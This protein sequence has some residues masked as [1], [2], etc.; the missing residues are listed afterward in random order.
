MDKF[1]K[2][3]GNPHCDAIWHNIPKKITRCK[4]CNGNII[5]INEKTYNK[6]FKNNFFQ[7]DYETDEYYRIIKNEFIQLTLFN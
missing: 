5:I 3:C 7:Y 1:V 2:I 6:K 4:N